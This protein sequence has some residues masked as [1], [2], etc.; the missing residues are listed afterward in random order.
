M[1][2]LGKIFHAN[3]LIKCNRDH[4]FSGEYHGFDDWLNNC[5]H[6]YQ[7]NIQTLA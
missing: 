5:L 1:E 6:T 4:E 3:A 7:L 2:G